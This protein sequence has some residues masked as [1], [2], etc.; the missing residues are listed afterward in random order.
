MIVWGGNAGGTV[1][2]GEGGRWDP[3]SDLWQPTST[4]GAP[5]PRSSHTAIWTGERM[6][7]WGGSEII[8]P[9]V[10]C[11]WSASGGRYDPTSDTWE[12]TSQ[13]DTPPAMTGH[14]ATWTGDAMIVWGARVGGTYASGPGLTDGDGDTFRCDQDC[15]DAN[16]DVWDLP[17]EAGPV[18]FEADAATISWAP[19]A[20]NGLTVVYDTLRSE[21][22]SDFLAAG[23]CVE[24]EGADETAFDD[25]TPAA[26]GIFHYLV[27]ARN[28]CGYGP[29]GPAPTSGRTGRSC[30]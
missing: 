21:L 23:T 12:P 17:G 20:P 29:L 9:G 2:S 11:A 5:V 14:E 22:A 19:A 4:D 24:P 7:V 16:P 8:S 30:P 18:Q 27:R 3:L 15:D 1:R 25:S 13:A 28:A 6:V 26:G 10:C